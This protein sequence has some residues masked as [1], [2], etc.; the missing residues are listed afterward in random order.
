MGQP[1]KLSHKE[2]EARKLQPSLG[3]EHGKL[4][5]IQQMMNS[6]NP[7]PFDTLRFWALDVF[8]RLQTFPQSDPGV[9]ACT[10]KALEL[11]REAQACMNFTA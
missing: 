8:R 1:K 2:R 10:K 3:K 11:A 4:T 5:R 9:A 7:P 6:E